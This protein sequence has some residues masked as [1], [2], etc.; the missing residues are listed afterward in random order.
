LVF[1]ETV[2]RGG[3]LAFAAGQA[4]RVLP[5][6]PRLQ[7]NFQACCRLLLSRWYSFYA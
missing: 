3:L 5:S 1:S 4:E 2:Y 7:K 6:S